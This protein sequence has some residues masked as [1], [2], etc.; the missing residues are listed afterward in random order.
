MSTT[1]SGAGSHRSPHPGQSA[2][3]R[4]RSECC[5]RTSVP[6][7]GK[8]RRIS[9]AAT[10][11]LVRLG[12]RH[13]DVDD[14]HR[15]KRAVAESARWFTAGRPRHPAVGEGRA[16]P[17]RMTTASSARGSR[18]WIDAVTWVRCRR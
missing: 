14:G 12:G 4:I 10:R 18:A 16:T 7:V 3:R 15:A 8:R 11:P 6:M 17:W 5:D 2:R 9:R 13:A 1:R